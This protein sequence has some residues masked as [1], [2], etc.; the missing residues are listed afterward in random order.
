MDNKDVDIEDVDIEELKIIVEEMDKNIKLIQLKKQEVEKAIRLKCPI[1][2]SKR[3]IFVKYWLDIAHRAKMPRDLAIPL[4]T[5]IEQHIIDGPDYYTECGEYGIIYIIYFETLEDNGDR[6][7]IL[8]KRVEQTWRIVR[9]NKAKTFFASE[10]M[11][12]PAFDK[13]YLPVDGAK[14][15]QIILSL[16]DVDSEDCYKYCGIVEIIDTYEDMYNNNN[17]PVGYELEES[18]DNFIE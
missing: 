2:L 1:Y 18:D 12:G 17:F 6:V 11:L 14:Y 13:N 16:F 5:K 8:M 7:K 10:D 3:K 4:M 9:C 15:W